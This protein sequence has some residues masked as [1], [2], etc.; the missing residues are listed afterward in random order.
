MF[1]GVCNVCSK[2]EGHVLRVET[3]RK[4]WAVV[5][6]LLISSIT[7]L[8]A[9]NSIFRYN[10]FYIVIFSPPQ[11]HRQ[12]GGRRRR[13]RRFISIFVRSNN[14]SLSNPHAAHS[15]RSLHKITIQPS[16]TSLIPFFGF[17]CLKFF[18]KLIKKKTIPQKEHWLIS[19]EEVLLWWSSSFDS[20]SLFNSHI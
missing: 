13:R 19:L 4:R 20:E 3:K 6:I 1:G 8:F 9:Y 18:I 15:F 16:V 2:H 17:T 11:P 10:L 5:V 7:S 14:L 12:K